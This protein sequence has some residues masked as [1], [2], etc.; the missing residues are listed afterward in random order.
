MNPATPPKLAPT[1]AEAIQIINNLVSIFQNHRAQAA[2]RRAELV[3][4]I[5]TTD[6]SAAI[7]SHP[8]K[9]VTLGAEISALRAQGDLAEI[10]VESSDRRIRE[11]GPTA[12]IEISRLQEVL[13][14]LLNE[15]R[16]LAQRMSSGRLQHFCGAVLEQADIDYLARRSPVMRT[17]AAFEA[18]NPA[19]ISLPLQSTATNTRIATLRRAEADFENSSKSEVG[20]LRKEN[21]ALRERLAAK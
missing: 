20:L 8:E 10:A 7:A 21:A 17:Q 9:L 4:L 15:S 14:G 6:I 18:T 3:D 12:W 1:P 16:G 13:A 5:G 19:N 11:L 2:A